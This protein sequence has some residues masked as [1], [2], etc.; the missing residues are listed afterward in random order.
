VALGA[1]SV[2]AQME[3]GESG[4]K[5]IQ[6]CFRFPSQ[7]SYR[8]IKEAFQRSHIEAC[9]SFFDSWKYCTKQASRVAGPVTHGPIPKPPKRKGRSTKEFN[10]LVLGGSLEELVADGSVHIATYPKLLQAKQ[11]F[12]LRTA[13]HASLP[14]LTNEW[15][16]G[17]TGTGKTRGVS[18]KFPILFRKNPNKWWDGYQGEETVLIDDVD[19]K[20]DGLGYYLKIWGDHYPFTAECKGSSM[21]IRP[22]TIIVTSNYH[23]RDIWNSPEMVDPILRR[24]KLHHY[25]RAP[26]LLS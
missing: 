13:S 14:T 12:Q 21:Q 2:V 9:K 20:H 24:F 25:D 3:V 11:L 23:P 22:K 1:E 19:T 15:H 7:R 26:A 17:P 8:V 18:S 4:T 10:E 16:F 6:S 5:H